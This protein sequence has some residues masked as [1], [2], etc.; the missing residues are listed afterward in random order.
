MVQKRGRTQCNRTIKI[1]R[2]KQKDTPKYFGMSH[3]LI[4]FMNALIGPDSSRRKGKISVDHVARPGPRFQGRSPAHP[5]SDLG[6]LTPQSMRQ[7]PEAQDAT[8]RRK[9]N[10]Y[11]ASAEYEPGSGFTS[12]FF[13]LIVVKHGTSP[14]PL[15]EGLICVAGTGFDYVRT[16]GVAVA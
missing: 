5:T 6:D 3:I 10:G 4:C 15:C 7:R 11:P 14:R 9:A 16:P 13:V 2:L 1:C 8:H 12:G